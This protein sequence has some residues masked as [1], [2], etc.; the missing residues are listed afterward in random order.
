MLEKKETVLKD[1]VCQ[2]GRTGALTPL[3]ILEPVRV[4]PVIEAEIC[5]QLRSRRNIMLLVAL[6]DR[7]TLSIILIFAVNLLEHRMAC[8]I[9]YRLVFEDDFCTVVDGLGHAWSR[10]VDILTP[11]ESSF[12]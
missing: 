12:H 11:A 3:A 5:G 10:S 2:V 7:I 9:W 4:G 1:I 8:P 6:H